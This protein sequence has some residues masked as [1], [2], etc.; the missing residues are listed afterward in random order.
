MSRQVERHA[1]SIASAEIMGRL[2]H[3]LRPK[4]S[5]C[6]VSGK[7]DANAFVNKTLEVGF[8]RTIAGRDE[9]GPLQQDPK[10]R[11][12]FVATGDDPTKTDLERLTDEGVRVFLAAYHAG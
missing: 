4:R 11:A 12:M 2:L 3:T 6:T 9:H 5:A 7:K 1:S 8:R 10:D